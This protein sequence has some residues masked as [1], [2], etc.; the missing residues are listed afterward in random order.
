MGKR[1]FKKWAMRM[2]KI[3]LPMNVFVRLLEIAYKIIE[4]F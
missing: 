2:D 3:I 4:L 1:S